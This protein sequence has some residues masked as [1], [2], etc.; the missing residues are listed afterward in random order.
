[1]ETVLT[2]ILEKMNQRIAEEDVSNQKLAQIIGMAVDMREGLFEIASEKEKGKF[3]LEGMEED[4]EELT[5]VIVRANYKAQRRIN[6]NIPMPSVEE[7][8]E[9]ALQS[10]ELVKFR[11]DMAKLRN[12]YAS[13]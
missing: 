8:I 9:E 5:R 4:A 11:K 2:S 7:Q 3:N 12:K 1:M 6:P 10:K 13:L